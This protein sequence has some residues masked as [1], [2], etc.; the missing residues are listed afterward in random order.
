MVWI[1]CGIGKED[2]SGGV[3]NNLYTLRCLATAEIHTPIEHK[4]VT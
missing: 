3:A 2:L 4:I 1:V